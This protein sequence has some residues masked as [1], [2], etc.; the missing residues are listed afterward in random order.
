MDLRCETKLHGRLDDGILEVKCSS[1]FCGARPGIL[2]YHRFN[3]DDGTFTT[4]SYLEVPTPKM[5]EGV[6]GSSRPD[7]SLR[8]A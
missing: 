1:K 7:S 5:K 4:A 6:N 8:T 2:V 3:L